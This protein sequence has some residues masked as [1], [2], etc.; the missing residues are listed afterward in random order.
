[1]RKLGAASAAGLAA[2]AETAYLA[3]RR[4]GLRSMTAA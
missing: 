4:D 1:L 3:E 2:A